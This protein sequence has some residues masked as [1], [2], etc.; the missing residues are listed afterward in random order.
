MSAL[1][2]PSSTSPS[3]CRDLMAP[4]PLHCPVWDCPCAGFLFSVLPTSGGEP[5]SISGHPGRVLLR[6]PFPAVGGSG[7]GWLSCPTAQVRTDPIHP[8]APGE[9]LRLH[10]LPAEGSGRSGVQ[11]H[12][13]ERWAGPLLP[14][15]RDGGTALTAV[16]PCRA[17]TWRAAGWRCSSSTHPTPH[18]RPDSA[19][20]TLRGGLEPSSSRWALPRELLDPQR[21]PECCRSS[22][23]HAR[24]W[25]HVPAAASR[26]FSP[27]Q[28]A[29]PHLPHCSYLV[30]LPRLCP[31]CA[32]LG[33]TGQC[34][35][36]GTH[37]DSPSFRDVRLL[38]VS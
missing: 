21:S 19:R 16:P 22:G 14:L 34:G 33:P 36:V 23:L 4:P 31:G 1:Q 5:R 12:A 26:A 11:S 20:R 29:W 3:L 7:G 32:A 13:G 25:S 6:F 38:W 15:L 8:D 18:R 17:L 2:C 27:Q 28:Q 35:G 30:P 37:R 9:V 10:Q 24:L